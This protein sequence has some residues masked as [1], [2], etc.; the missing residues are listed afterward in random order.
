MTRGFKLTGYINPKHSKQGTCLCIGK[1]GIL[2]DLFQSLL[3]VRSLLEMKNFSFEII[4]LHKPTH[5]SWIFVSKIISDF[6]KLK[7]LPDYDTVLSE[8]VSGPEEGYGF[9]LDYFSKISEPKTES[10]N[11]IR[12]FVISETAVSLYAGT[13]M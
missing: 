4:P 1:K 11:K 7:N 9:V 5:E 13:C 12:E 10:E 8:W 3:V 2:S 6:A